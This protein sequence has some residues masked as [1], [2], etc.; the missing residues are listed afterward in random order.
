MAT[1]DTRAQGIDLLFSTSDGQCERMRELLTAGVDPNFR[2]YDK[3]SPMHVAA[4]AEN[5]VQAIRLLLDFRADV[6]VVDKWG[7]TPLELVRV[8][9]NR[10]AERLLIAKGAKLGKSALKVSKAKGDGKD[11]LDSK[12][13]KARAVLES[14]EIRR[15]DVHIM[16]QI[17]KTLK[18]EVHLATWNG[19]KVVAKF[20]TT[21]ESEDLSAHELEDELLHEVAVLASLRHPDLVMFL[22]CSLYES[23]MMF[24]EEFLSGGDLEHYYKSKRVEGRPWAP[25]QNVVARWSCCI[26]RGL[27]YLHTCYAGA[28]IHR[29]LKPLNVLL[30]ASLDDVKLADFGISRLAQRSKQNGTS[31]TPSNPGGPGSPCSP[32]WEGWDGS[33]M[34]A[35]MT[36]GVGTWRYMAP[37]VARHDAYTV[38]ADIYSFA[39]ILYFMASGRQPFYEF[40]DLRNLLDQYSS[41]KEPRPKVSECP[42][43][44]RTMLEAAWHIEPDSR[45]SAEA[46]LGEL[47]ELRGDDRSCCKLM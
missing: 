43:A 17:S 10:E 38:K 3:R 2:D 32:G 40:K 5:S 26:C 36:G 47:S 37:E 21:A 33:P 39:L 30:T 24:I 27:R 46:L 22:G 28:I 12:A 41:G 29:D 8:G 34:S 23:P 16:N 9:E 31:S 19:L 44:F 35:D 13:V 11:S 20:V 18:S 15:E 14:C 4:G 25:A 7:T 6:D 42:A 1:C 45:P